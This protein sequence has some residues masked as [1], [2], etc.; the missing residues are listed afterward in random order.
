MPSRKYTGE[1]CNFS[2]EKA[3]SQGMVGAWQVRILATKKGMMTLFVCWLER[4]D[5]DSDQRK[6]TSCRASKQIK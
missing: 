6:A 1:A 4:L 5:S 3:I 2:E